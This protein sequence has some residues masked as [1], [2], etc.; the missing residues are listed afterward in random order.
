MSNADLRLRLRLTLAL[1]QIRGVGPVTARELIHALA[2]FPQMADELSDALDAISERVKRPL[3][4]SITELE[5]AFS[6]ADRVLEECARSGIGV[7]V[8]GDS[9]FWDGV[10]RIP[11]APLLVYYRGKDMTAASVPGVAVIG[12]R[13]P[14][15]YGRKSGHRIAMTCVQGGMA[16]V[17]GLAIGCDAAAHRGALDSGGPT[18]AVLAHGLH[19]VRPRQ[20]REL[21]EEIVDTGGLLV[22]EYAPGVE[23][24]SNQLVERNRLQAGLSRGLIVI[25]TDVKGGTM[26]TVRFAQEQG[27]LIACVN[28]EPTMREA[29]KSRGNQ[30]LIREG[31]A[32]P[33]DS[34]EEVA[35]YLSRL[36][37]ASLTDRAADT[38]S[39]HY[40]Q[41]EFNFDKPTSA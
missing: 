3:H 31:V 7:A 35:A 13:E 24:R 38:A 28:H 9:K 23:F 41:Q 14:S 1:R 19:T 34:K 25:E 22:S 4:G 16:V 10:W 39:G 20:H 36:L 6:G 2:G 29:A 11:R 32:T 37:G 15:S 5:L 33:L 17:S 21:A 30:K 27:R 12:T 40:L 18:I 8:E 26:H